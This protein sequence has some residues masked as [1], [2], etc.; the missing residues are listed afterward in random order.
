MVGN[1]TRILNPNNQRLPRAKHC[2]EQF[3]EPKIKGR[4]LTTLPGTADLPNMHQRTKE[5]H[6]GHC[7]TKG[8][9]EALNAFNSAF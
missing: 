4:P 8:Q 6:L 2:I 5:K 7:P 3:D 1:K 9:F